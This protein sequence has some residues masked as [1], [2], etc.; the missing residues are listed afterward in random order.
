MKSGPGKVIF[1]VRDITWLRTTP[2]ASAVSSR[3]RNRAEMK[4]ICTSA[5]FRSRSARLTAYAGKPFCW[6]NERVPGYNTPL[7]EDCVQPIASSIT[8]TQCAEPGQKGDCIHQ[9]LAYFLAAGA[10]QSLSA[11]VQ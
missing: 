10:P 8:P 1:P 7:N 3:L 5:V 4:T 9:P 6:T 11:C 2:A